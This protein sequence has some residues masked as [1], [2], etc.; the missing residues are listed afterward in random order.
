MKTEIPMQQTVEPIELAAKPQ[1]NTAGSERISGRTIGLVLSAAILFTIL[2]L[3]S[4]T[5]L[6]AYT[7]QILARQTSLLVLVALSQAFCL[8]AGGMN[9]SVGAIG[10]FTTVILGICM[11]RF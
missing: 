8:V 3:Q 1:K 7:M 6:S 4:S 2:T 5:F 9:L 11:T 10:G